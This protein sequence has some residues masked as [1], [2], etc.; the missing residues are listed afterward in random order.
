MNST[1]GNPPTVGR[2]S[3]HGLAWPEQSSLRSR[4]RSAWIVSLTVHA[5]LLLMLA[6]IARGTIQRERDFQLTTVFDDAE[7]EVDDREIEYKI[8]SAI[9]ENVG[10]ETD[11]NMSG[12][13]QALATTKGHDPQQQLRRQLNEKVFTVNIPLQP[14]SAR[15]N[16]ADVLEMVDTIGTTERP[17]GVSG[18]IDILTRE[19]ATSLRERE[20]LVIW[21]FDASLSLKERRAAIADRFENI[22]RQL[23]QLDVGADT[24][25]KTAVVA[26]GRRTRILTKNPTGDVP[27]LVKA[28][29]NIKA[30]VSG[31][32]RVFAAVESVTKR[33]LSFGKELQHN[34]MIVVVTD[35]RG[36]DISN[37]EHSIAM[38]R[39]NGIR[40]YC[41]GSESAFGRQQTTVR[42][43][44]EDG[45]SDDLP[46]DR[47]PETLALERLQLPFWGPTSRYIDQLPSGF[48]PY[49]L[50]R[51][52]TETG[53]MYLIAER[54]SQN[55]DSDIMLS[56]EPD[57]RPVKVYR[58][59]VKKNLAKRSLV[60]AAQSQLVQKIPR[61]RRRF[62]ADRDDIL[63][64]QLNSA[65]RPLALLDN[66]LR[67]THAILERG[68]KD[69]AKLTEPRW[70][71]SFDLAMGRVLAMRVRAYGYN[72]VLAEMKVNPKPFTRP[73][74]NLWQLEPSRST[75]GF[76]SAIAK[77]ADRAEKYLTGVIE[78]HPGTPW[79]VIAQTELREPLGWQW[80]ESYRPI[81]KV[82]VNRNGP[83]RPRR[84][85][86]PSPPQRVKPKL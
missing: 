12:P 37:V 18:A 67:R 26:F 84:Q 17:G 51:L 20:T 3:K 15:P 80:E 27:E 28:V 86:R 11:M 57:Y 14:N 39:R 52:C 73:E 13:T 2:E 19:I 5:L 55:F 35:E 41:V 36:D 61:P 54:S 66:Y 21:L 23:D 68:E 85:Q 70:K 8:D 47:G 74:N 81:P 62:R 83:V 77:M 79:A 24:A 9:V 65:Q 48:G 38:V 71:A 46:V 43:E 34:V 25:L 50:T 31:T 82:T 7:E 29:R 59:D 64:R 22:Y 4:D 49:A 45:A 1:A 42:W 72:A 33:W 63:K 78:E 58:K 75:E 69:R 56:Y 30:D 76:P 32:E 10:S 6:A 53:G 40:V 44:Y 60:E 16:K